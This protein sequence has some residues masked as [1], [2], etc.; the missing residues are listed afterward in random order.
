[1]LKSTVKV[2]MKYANTSQAFRT[3]AAV[4]SCAHREGIAG[5]AARFILHVSD[6]MNQDK[7]TRFLL[8]RNRTATALSHAA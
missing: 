8:R 3:E 1:V 5:T 7:G 6:R 4:L 2:L